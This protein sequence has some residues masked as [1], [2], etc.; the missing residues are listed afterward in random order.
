MSNFV[1]N[2]FMSNYSLTDIWQY[3]QISHK[4]P[5]CAPSSSK[6]QLG[7]VKEAMFFVEPYI[8]EKSLKGYLS[9]FSPYP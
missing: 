3:Y 2:L 5:P 9:C 6:M 1:L 4:A 8:G 7:G